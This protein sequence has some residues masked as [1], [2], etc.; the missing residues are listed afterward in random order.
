MTDTPSLFDTPAQVRAARDDGI[1]RAD[2]HAND[3]W[4]DTAW[5]ALCACARDLDVFTADDVWARL[6]GPELTH[7][8]SALGPLFLA[9]ARQGL[10]VKTGRMPLTR[11]A[12][13]HRNLTEW[14]A[15]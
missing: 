5:R 2:A 14:R 11:Y 6:D 4:R 15:A 9:A 13:R 12:R 7:N 8:P 10:I 1:T 3:E